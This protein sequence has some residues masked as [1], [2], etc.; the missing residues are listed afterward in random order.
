MNA[1][2][3][4][5]RA[6]L[7]SIKAV[8]AQDCQSA[9]S[10]LVQIEVLRERLAQI[11]RIADSAITRLHMGEAEVQ[12]AP[13]FLAPGDSLRDNALTLV[14]AEMDRQDRKWGSQRKQPSGT[15]L[16]ILV[17]EVGEVAEAMLDED[18]GKSGDNVQTETVQVA[19]VAVQYVMTRLQS[20]LD[21]A[22]L[23]GLS[24]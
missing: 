7:D 6:C 18:N 17:E 22:K 12:L 11:G 13:P 20:K 21:A 5:A 16:K 23:R 8:V 19:A 4:Q 24:T 3:N 15:W 2:L 10:D 1:N 9:S 14:I